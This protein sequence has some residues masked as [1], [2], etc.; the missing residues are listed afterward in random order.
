MKHLSMF[1]R[2]EK[3][4]EPTKKEI[5]LK[6]DLMSLYEKI[7]GHVQDSVEYKTIEKDLYS[8]EDQLYKMQVL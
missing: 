3:Y 2:D 1:R 8:T 5:T 7:E 6:K 4:E